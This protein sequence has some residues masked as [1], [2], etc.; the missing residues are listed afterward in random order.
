MAHSTTIKRLEGEVKNLKRSRENYYQ[1]FQDEKEKHHFYFMFKGD[2]KPY[3]DGYFIGKILLPH[4]YPNNPG[5]VLVLTPN[6]RFKVNSK[7]CLSNTGFHKE[8]HSPIW[9]IEQ[10][11][12]G[13]ISIFYDDKETGVSHIKDTE[14]NRIMYSDDSFKYNM[15]KYPDIMKRFDQFVDENN[16]A[17]SDKEINQIIQ[18]HK[19]KMRKKKEKKLAKEAKRAEKMKKRESAKK[20]IS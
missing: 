20:I 8:S 2:Q 6:G 19:E 14:S 4:D 15:N 9:T 1:V 5:D 10:I 11:V 16:L 3:I 7:I 13:F 12:V 17:R 18:D